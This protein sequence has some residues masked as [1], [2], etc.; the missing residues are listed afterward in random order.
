MGWRGAIER[1]IV[2]YVNFDLH[3]PVDVTYVQCERL[4]KAI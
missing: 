4:T 3:A 2:T 1:V